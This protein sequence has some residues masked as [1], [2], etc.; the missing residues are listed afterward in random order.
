MP[1]KTRH[2]GRFGVTNAEAQAVITEHGWKVRA[3]DGGFLASRSLND[4]RHA[5]V[6]AETLQAIAEYV[7]RGR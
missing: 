3:D 1:S 4:Q 7:L 6:R 2:G 5:T